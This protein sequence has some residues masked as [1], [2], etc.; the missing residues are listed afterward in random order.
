VSQLTGFSRA[1][2]APLPPRASVITELIADELEQ[3]EAL[4]RSNL[5]APVSI[6]DEIGGYL[7]AGGGKRVRPTLHLLTTR[8]C[9]YHGPHGVLLATVLEFIHS[10]T[11]IHDDIIDDA[12]TRRGKPSV[13]FR[14]GNNITVLFGD[15]LFAK[16]MEMALS[17]GRIEIMQG[18]AEASLRMTE[19]E[20]LQTRYVGRVDLTEDEYLGLIER[21]TA[22]LFACCCELAGLLADSSEARRTAL[23]A[24]G[25]NLGMAFQLVDDL[26]DFTGDSKKLGKPAA[27]D[28]REGKATLAVIDLL[29]RGDP[30][31]HGL[32]TRV[33]DGAAPESPETTALARM[34]HEHGSIRRVGDRAAGFAAEAVRQLDAFEDGEARRALKS[35]PDLLI[36]RD[37]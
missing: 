36:A 13:N 27:S 14:W 28:L 31:A 5:A 20:M 11:L 29:Q 34:L 37:R 6:V 30:E 12:T 10:A 7:A 18:L 25:L 3:V 19:G 32:V 26:L 1:E 9:G 35:L 8:L 33:M 23:R 2:S 24:Y 15:Y 16:A 4:F 21:K 22:A 17:A